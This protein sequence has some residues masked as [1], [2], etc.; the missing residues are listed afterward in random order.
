[1]PLL[2]KVYTPDGTVAAVKIVFFAVIKVIEYVVLLTKY[3]CAGSVSNES[4]VVMRTVPSLAMPQP[5]WD[6]IQGVPI[7]IKSAQ[8]IPVCRRGK[9]QQ[10]THP[11]D[12]KY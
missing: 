1:M 6:N 5:R 4:S 2:D 12:K 9:T 11:D 3:C 8:E 10:K 7:T